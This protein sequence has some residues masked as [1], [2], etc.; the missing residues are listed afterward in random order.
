MVIDELPTAGDLAKECL[1]YYSIWAFMYT[2]WVF[3]LSQK[4][5]RERNYECT[6]V[7]VF[8]LQLF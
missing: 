5:I 3:V 7:Y 2:I 6:F 4:K 1:F 8:R